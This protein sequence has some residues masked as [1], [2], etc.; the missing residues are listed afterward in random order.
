MT[1]DTREIRLIHEADSREALTQLLHR[2]YASLAALGLRYRA[3]H[4]D[5]A[6]TQRRIAQGECYV[7]SDGTRVV[8]TVLLIPPSARSTHCAWYDR[9]DVA[10]ISQFA[11]EPE[12]QRQGLGRR[13]LDFAERRALDLGALE[14]AVDT[15]EP[16]VHL[17]ELYQARGYRFVCHAQWDHTNF[18]SVV[19]SKRLTP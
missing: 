5:V 2:A 7:L 1:A 15:A 16:A 17:V 10:V 19:L 4:Q 11:V 18:R 8:G 13:L 14:V 3:T 12:L 9:L 6:T